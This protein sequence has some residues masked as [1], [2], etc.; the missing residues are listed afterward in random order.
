MPFCLALLCVLW[1]TAVHAGGD[2]RINHATT[3][4]VWPG[5]QALQ[6]LVTPLMLE[7][8][9]WEFAFWV[10]GVGILAFMYVFNRCVRRAASAA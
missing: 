3:P 4:Q 2:R 10:W 1:E 8:P 5:A 6:N 7:G 9:G